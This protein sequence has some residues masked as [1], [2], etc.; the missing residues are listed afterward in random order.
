MRPCPNCGSENADNARFCSSCGASLTSVEAAREERKV[1]TVLFADLVGFT[2]RA[3]Q[4]DP[5]DVRALVSP[6]YAHLKEEL[7]RH[8]GTV[9]KF[10]GDAVM[11]LFGAPVAHEDD[12]ERAVRAALA[13]RDW[14][15]EQGS[16][17]HVRLAVTTGEALVSLGARPAEG[18]GMAAGD[19]VNTA[20]RLQTAAPVDGILVDETTYRATEQQI[21]YRE[22]EPVSA[23]GK[24]EPVPAWE[25]L[26]ARSRF[27]VDT[28]LAPRAPLIGRDREL[29]VLVSALERV[30]ADSSPQ[31]VTLVGVP[32]I[33]KSRLVYELFQ[34]VER[35]PDYIYWRQ[36]RSLP[37]G[38]GVSFWALGEM[39]KAQTGILETD[40]P[41][42]AAAKLQR[43][44][45][46]LVA[47]A[48]AAWVLRHLGPLVG[49]E[50]DQE[51]DADRRTEASAAWRTFFEAIAEDRPLVLVFDDLHWADDGLVDFVDHLVEWASGVPILVVCTARPELLTRRPGWGGGKTNAVTLSLSPLDDEQT[52]RLLAALLDRSVLPAETQTAL[53]QRSGGNPLYA[54][55][56]V[57]MVADR[58]LLAGDGDLPM[59]ES[60]QGIVAARLDGLPGEEKALLLDAAVIGKV[61]WLG[62]AASIRGLPRAAAE[63]TLHRLERKEFVRR[64]RRASVAGETEYA[65]R[66]LLVRDVAYGQIPR[67]RRAEKHGLAAGWIETLGRPEDHAEMLAHHYMTALELSRAAGAPTDALAERARPILRE[68]GDRA[69]SLGAYPAAKQFYGA[70]LQVWPAEDP[71]RPQ[72]LFKYASIAHRLDFAADLGLLEE[73]RD[74]L[75]AAEDL[76]TAAVAEVELAEKVWL[77]G[78]RDQAFESLARAAA[79]VEGRPPSHSKAQVLSNLSRYQMLAGEREAAITTG[80]EALAMIEELG[81]NEELRAHVLNNIGSSRAFAGDIGGIAEI[82]SSIQIALSVNSTESIRGYGNLAS[83]MADLARFDRRREMVALGAAEAKRFGVGDYS[84]WLAA[85]A[86]WH[87]YWEGKWDEALAG[88]DA[89]IA[90]FEE[91]R[92][93][94]EGPCRWLRARIHLARGDAG[95][96][97]ADAERTVDRARAG[98][99]PQ[100]LWP[101]LAFAARERAAVDPEHARGLTREVL[102]T[103]REQEYPSSGSSE[104]LS[105][106][107]V[108]LRAIGANGD[109]VAEASESPFWTPW[110]EA[111]V[112]FDSGDFAGAAQRYAEIGSLPD[113]AYARLCEAERLVRTGRRPEADSELQHALAFWRS[114]GATAYVREGEALLA[115]AG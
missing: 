72:L 69:K 23:K 60:V 104:W 24:E 5:E 88:L 36:G 32:G 49:L 54:E 50:S 42:D 22:A 113:E 100:V 114:V 98:K 93:W 84:G 62:A 6:Y 55:E 33:G 47:E 35:D 110:L 107:V 34:A 108:A 57:R 106:F 51:L 80:R 21:E 28:A 102:R 45:G 61:F 38:E 115:A 26:E 25:A 41:D 65:F 31:L 15:Q 109:L 63:D 64:E 59:P 112:A 16:D 82:E 58:G 11:A 95:A 7:E 40:A 96:A 73:A 10:I 13:I 103:W 101:A 86:L 85:E 56:F 53:L 76:D 48:D 66:H 19:V 89:L 75:L 20:A 8:G 79:L 27:G 94:M 12:P 111:A 46:D 1:V 71:D 70:A 105:D 97:K 3:E 18:E 68:A 99:D 14:L 43:A 2:S 90:D 74:A 29:D 4:L 77:R 44:V 91:S 92:Y 9:E 37:Y 67:A 30:R 78:E 81:G 39:V 17:L 83:I 52:A 87:P